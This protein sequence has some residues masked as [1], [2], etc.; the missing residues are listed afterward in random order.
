MILPY[1]K[2]FE[3]TLSI[4]DLAICIGNID[5]IKTHNHIGILREN[6]I[7][8]LN[9][10]SDKLHNMNGTI[11]SRNGWYIVNKN[12][13]KPFNNNKIDGNVPLIFSDKFKNI[14]SYSLKYL[15]DYE[16]IFYSDISYID[17]S[18]R[19]DIVTCLFAKDIPKLAINEDPWSST[20]RQELRIGRFLSK[21]SDDSKTLIEDYVNEYKFSYK[22]NAENFNKFKI[23]KGFDM[24]K[25][26]LEKNYALG[27]GSLNQSCMRFIKSQRRLPIYVNNPNK[28]KLLYILNLEGKV[29]ARALLWKL[30]EPKRVTYMDRIYCVD[31]Y[32]EKLFLDYAD[33]KGILTRDKAINENIT[34]K[35]Y[36]DE[37]YGPP[38]RNPF[39]DTFRYFNKKE[40][41]LTNK[42]EKLKDGE[43]WEYND[44]D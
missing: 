9:N 12:W 38:Q 22:L 34:M 41:Y 30:D 40:Y 1:K 3:S 31:D 24:S 16:N 11:H 6:G 27:G 15:L 44:H 28:I 19:N 18:F 10:F 23:T 20:M 33:K 2:L 37:D 35:V 5:G 36:L 26:Y 21:I 13:L 8:F 7:E 42:L 39:M 32:L 25:F 4:G 14:I 43:F 17:I 29:L